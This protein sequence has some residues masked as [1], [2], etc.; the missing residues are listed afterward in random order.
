MI[1]SAP[2]LECY[3]KP[4]VPVGELGR[5]ASGRIGVYPNRGVRRRIILAAGR[6]DTDTAALTPLDNKMIIVGSSSDHLIADVEDCEKKPRPG[7]YVSFRCGYMA[8]LNACTS[9]YV[10]KKFI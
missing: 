9:E 1:F 8:M 6:Q 3:S 7:D 2:V 10:E 5:D 4:S